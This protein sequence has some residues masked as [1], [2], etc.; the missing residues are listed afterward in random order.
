VTW[1]VITGD[2]LAAMRSLDAESVDAIVTDPPSGIRFMGQAWDAD[3]GGMEA[4]VEW[5]A[6]RLA[7]A[8]RV[9]KPGAHALVWA[10]PRTSHW[11][12]LALER[13]GWDVRDV[14]THLFGSGFPKSLD[15][16]KAID[17]AARGV[18]QGG[19]DPTSPNHGRFK[20]G[21]SEDNPSGSGFGAGPGAFMLAATP[22]DTVS[23]KIAPPP[24]A[25]TAADQ[26]LTTPG[27][28]AS[29][30][31]GWG[32]ALKPAAEMWFLARKP[33][34]GN[35]ASNVLKHGT[36][37][38]NIDGCRVAHGT[39]NGGNLADN[40]HP[41]ESTKNTGSAFGGDQEAAVDPSGR[42][43]ANVV[44]SHSPGCV[45]V[46]TRKVRS[47]SPSVPQPKFDSDQPGVSLDFKA[48]VGRNGERSQG[49]AEADGT[50]TVPAW[51]CVEGCP[52]AML[53]AQS[54]SLTSGGGPLNRNADKFRTAYGAFAGGDEPADVLYGDTGSAS[55]FFYC[56]KPSSAE[57]HNAG[58]NPHT[59]V[60]SVALMQYLLRL[61]TP[62]GTVLDPFAG[63]GT[64]GMA[65]LREGFSFIGIEENAEFAALARER[66]VADCPLHNA[67]A[68][69]PESAA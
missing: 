24:P 69:M 17:K 65:A 54:G 40:P 30:W 49:Y 39:V 23:A 36:G 26:Q 34:K 63:S 9:A 55:R 44:L 28:T 50:E 46:G 53:D 66:I 35:V 56:A 33:F 5:L 11:T 6:E 19:A 43:P 16:S 52:V 60:K 10:L 20:A 25:V 13:A 3:R 4:W 29:E 18:P 38:L 47:Q 1:Q 14:V 27:A 58:R 64:T 32:T 45:E 62:G 59:T 22:P 68:E 8:L 12:G 37:A 21:C 7:E 61:V 51:E 42:W 67:A 48:G 57:R 2:C 31:D 41:R 15:V